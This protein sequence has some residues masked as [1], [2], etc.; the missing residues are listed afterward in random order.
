MKNKERERTTMTRTIL[1]H[2]RN[3]YISNF[4]R[5]GGPVGYDEIYEHTYTRILY[6][7]YVLQRFVNA[8]NLKNTQFL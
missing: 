8:M 2:T 6:L 1:L 4:I 7:R 3:K 5:D